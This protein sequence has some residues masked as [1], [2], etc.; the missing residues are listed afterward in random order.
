[1]KDDQF[2]AWEKTR[3]KG[4]LKFVLVTGVLLW[5]LPMLIFMAFINKPFTDGFTSKSAIIHCI[6]WP[7]AGVVYGLLTW[8]YSERKYKKN[9]ANRSNI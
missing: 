6:V 7:L 2:K 3:T 9:L 4:K 8:H 1:M 5:G